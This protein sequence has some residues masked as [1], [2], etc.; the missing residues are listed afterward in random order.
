MSYSAYSGLSRLPAGNAPD[1]IIDGCIVLEGGAFRGVYGEGVLD[2]LMQHGVNL[3]CTVGCSAGALNGLN[4][5]AGQI[6]RSARINLGY[7][8]DPRYVGRRPLLKEGSLISFDFLFKQTESFEPLNRKRFLDSRRRFAVVVANCESGEA[9]YPEKGVCSDIFRAVQ[10]SASMP[11]VSHMVDVD[12]HPCLDGGRCCKI[13]Y[14][15]AY[16]QGY[17]KV[18]IVRTRHR[19]FRKPPASEH[20]RSLATRF[21]RNFPAFANKL[22]ESDADYNRQCDEIGDLERMG[23]AFVIAPSVHREIGRLEKDMQKLGHL[24]WLGY[25]DALERMD[26]LRKY[27]N[28]PGNDC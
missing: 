11:F 28:M 26:S 6:G 18:V 15:W 24:Y 9:E 3:Q 17:Q 12:G 10:A 27:L 25:Y 2:A 13:P 21:Y 7:R 23:K 20:R 19:S 16:D 5:V 4:Y 14:H 8:N 22:A 1:T